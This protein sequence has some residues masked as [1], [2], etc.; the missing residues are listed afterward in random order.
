MIRRGVNG[1]FVTDDNDAARLAA[2]NKVPVVRTWRLLKVAAT[3]EWSTPTPWGYSQTLRNQRR[4]SPPG[5]IDRPLIRQVAGILTERPGPDY[6]FLS[7]TSR[8]PI[9]VRCGS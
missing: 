7:K 1:F 6:V 3:K 8:R 2:R 5:V 4:G 9:K